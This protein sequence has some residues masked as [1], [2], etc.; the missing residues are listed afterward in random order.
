M[1]QEVVRK[2][3]QEK[4]DNSSHWSTR[5]M[6]AATGLSLNSEVEDEFHRFR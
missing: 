5:T 6:A 2:T 4:P 1:V 3:T